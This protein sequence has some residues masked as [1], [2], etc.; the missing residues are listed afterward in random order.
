MPRPL[1]R[2]DYSTRF[3]ASARRK[4]NEGSEPILRKDSA[5]WPG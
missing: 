2:R 3:A 5:R 1:Y 4:P